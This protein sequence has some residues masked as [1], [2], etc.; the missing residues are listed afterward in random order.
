MS[1]LW[2]TYVSSTYH[3]LS[4]HENERLS[5]SPRITSQP[6]TVNLKI[7]DKWTS[8]AKTASLAWIKKKKLYQCQWSSQCVQRLCTKFVSFESWWSLKFICHK[9]A[10]R[11][12]ATQKNLENENKIKL[13]NLK[14]KFHLDWRDSEMENAKF[15]NPTITP[16]GRKVTHEEE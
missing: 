12:Y 3:Y 11:N 16:S 13:E 7:S 5:I 1:I 6:Q 14:K 10:T 9:I 2:F 8:A 15:Q 4:Y